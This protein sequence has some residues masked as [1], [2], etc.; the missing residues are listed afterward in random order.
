MEKPIMS[1]S[2]NSELAHPADFG[3]IDS[4]VRILLWS[5]IAYFLVSIITIPFAG[6]LWWGEMPLLALIQ[7]PKLSSAIWF[8]TSVV[9]PWIVKLGYSAGSFSPDY[10][11]ARPYGLL[12]PYALF[13]IAM[14]LV[15]GV[16]F[17]LVPR[18]QRRRT[19]VPFMVS[20]LLA[21]IDYLMI[22]RFA[23]GP[24]FSMY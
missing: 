2:S 3:G 21:I 22:L 19:A 15:L 12:F 5:S 16:R 4:V 24:G 14:L 10:L 17:A 18:S 7:V 11:L 23:G 1:A 20:L 13:L 6:S 8:R 9:M